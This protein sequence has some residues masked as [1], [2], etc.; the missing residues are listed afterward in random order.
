[1]EV[2]KLAHGIYQLSLK[3]KESLDKVKENR[4]AVEEFE[5]QILRPIQYLREK[6]ELLHDRG[7]QYEELRSELTVLRSELDSLLQKCKDMELHRGLT[8]KAWWNSDKIKGEIDSIQKRL[9]SCRQIYLVRI[10]ICL[11]EMQHGDN[12][13]KFG[14]V[15]ACLISDRDHNEG[16]VEEVGQCDRYAPSRDTAARDVAKT[17]IYP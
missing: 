10:E 13:V 12:F 17:T 15:G 11:Q 16:I 1:M 8:F 3:F 7:S 4:K 2:I 9:E 14:L 6:F 5:R